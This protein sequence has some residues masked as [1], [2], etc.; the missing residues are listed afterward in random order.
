MQ[1]YRAISTILLVSFTLLS[2]ISCS[3]SDKLAAREKITADNCDITVNLD[4]VEELSVTP[5]LISQF[6]T[7]YKDHYYELT[8]LPDFSAENNEPDWDDLSL[9]IL[10]RF[11]YDNKDSSAPIWQLS[12]TQF[13]ETM[14]KHMQ[15][16]I[17]T[18]KPSHYLDYENGLYTADGFGLDG[19]VYYRL[20]DIAED[21]Q[22]IYTATFDMLSFG[23][24]ELIDREISPNLNAVLDYAQ[25]VLHQDPKEVSSSG[26]KFHQAI[27]AIFLE[28]NYAELLDLSGQV[29]VQFTL[30]GNPDSPF[31]Y[32]SCLWQPNESA[33]FN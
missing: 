23:E 30:T 28:D 29:T 9:Y 10:L 6:F 27:E 8:Y 32:V 17:Y 18:D 3:P 2:C 24:L 26:P 1:S 31:Y 5:H 21:D 12:D 22:N 15:P 33:L 13:R 20:L 16:V 4:A 19:A 14:Q 7:Y 25:T 11:E